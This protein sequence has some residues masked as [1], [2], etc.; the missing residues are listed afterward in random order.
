LTYVG[1]EQATLVIPG[2]F[3]QLEIEVIGCPDES[4]QFTNVKNFIDYLAARAVFPGKSL[5]K[6]FV[7]FAPKLI[8]A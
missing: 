6:H 2:R 8:V 7:V 5:L 4:V 3:W 1:L